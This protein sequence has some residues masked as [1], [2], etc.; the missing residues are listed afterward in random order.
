M[1]RYKRIIA[2]SLVLILPFVASAPCLAAGSHGGGSFSNPDAIKDAD[3]FDE[4]KGHVDVNLPAP[5]DTTIQSTKNKNGD[6]IHVLHWRNPASLVPFES[7]DLKV[8]VCAQITIQYNNPA[9][10]KGELT[11]DRF[12]IGSTSYTTADTGYSTNLNDNVSRYLHSIQDTED[13]ANHFGYLKTLVDGVMLTP[14]ELASA[15]SAAL[16][17]DVGT[18][19]GNTFSKNI[20]VL[21]D[22]YHFSANFEYKS[23]KYYLRY[24]LE[25]EATLC[26]IGDDGKY[27]ASLTITDIPFI[28]PD[29]M[30]WP[31]YPNDAGTYEFT[32]A[33][34][35][36]FYR[37]YETSTMEP[38]DYSYKDGNE[39]KTLKLYSCFGCTFQVY[40]LAEDR[41]GTL[42]PACIRTI[43]GSKFINNVGIVNTTPFYSTSNMGLVTGQSGLESLNDVYAKYLDD[44]TLDDSVFSEKSYKASCWTSVK[45]KFTPKSSDGQSIE[46]EQTVTTYDEDG[47]EVSVDVS[48]IEGWLAKIYKKECEI[49]DWIKLNLV[50]NVT[51]T[52]CD[53]LIG[54]L[55]SAAQ[56]LSNTSSTKFPISLYM[57]TIA[58]V[59]CLASEPKTPDLRLKFVYKPLNID[60]TFRLDF[61]YFEEIHNICTFFFLGFFILALNP[62][63]RHTLEIIDRVSN[64]GAS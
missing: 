5:A 45:T 63:T 1:Q 13:F 60:E 30:T 33:Y 10:G 11:S 58:V 35:I 16:R 9:G 6:T 15:I 34:P 12:L 50:V 43:S 54:D 38:F 26:Q 56:T 14:E 18:A 39:T 55:L 37:E 64:K 28:A 36:V 52:V 44:G 42:F 61:S 49:L 8:Q 2:F 51:D 25:K 53:V 20:Q 19:L 59:G 31:I 23:V 47:N 48:G 29:G 24:Y 46:K 32:S 62:M 21:D 27:H 57:N 41:Y 22:A 17:L 7:D 4:Q 40:T 3:M